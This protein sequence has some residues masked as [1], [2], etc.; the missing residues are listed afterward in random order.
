MIIDMVSNT[1]TWLLLILSFKNI[2]E[3]RIEIKI[4]IKFSVWISGII[5]TLLSLLLEEKY[6]SNNRFCIKTAKI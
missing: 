5:K 6:I 3:K 1:V 4:T 2:I